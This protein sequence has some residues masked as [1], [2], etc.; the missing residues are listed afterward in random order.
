[1]YIL[2]N[3]NLIKN[4]NLGGLPFFMKFSLTEI[5]ANCFWED[6]K[7]KVEEKEGVGRGEVALGMG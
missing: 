5:L 7:R 3:K 6:E 1:M 2:H 4:K